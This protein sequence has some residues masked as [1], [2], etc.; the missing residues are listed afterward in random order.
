MLAAAA[1]CAAV[2]AV[3]VAWAGQS[4]DLS[5]ARTRALRMQDAAREASWRADAAEAELAVSRRRLDEL[6]AHVADMG[7]ASSGDAVL[8]HRASACEARV[9]RLT[10]ELARVEALLK[11]A[12]DDLE[13]T[14]GSAG[15]A[16]AD[17]ASSNLG[18]GLRG[19]LGGLLG[20]GRRGGAEVDPRRA[21]RARL[22]HDLYELRE[23]IRSAEQAD[24]A[25][26][27]GDDTESEARLGLGEDV[28]E[29]VEEERLNA[30]LREDPDSIR[31]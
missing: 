24:A 28:A 16:D 21:G 10:D 25:I 12:Q 31:E 8:A 5:V 22:E 20:G 3:A 1:A 19:G 15:G 9:D 13:K 26:A 23:E 4:A 29:D 18:G 17:G 27:D 6:E 14:L 7:R 30:V 2:R 11:G